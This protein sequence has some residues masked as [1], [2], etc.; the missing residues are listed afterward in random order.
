MEQIQTTADCASFF[1]QVAWT[2]WFIWKGMNEFIFNNQPIDPLSVLHR[3]RK[4]SAE[5][6]SASE[7]G[8]SL[9]P[10]VP[11]AA[12]FS[13]VHWFLPPSGQF[14]I[15]CDVAVQ[16]GSSQAVAAAILRNSTGQLIDGLIQKWC[17]S[18][19]FQGEALAKLI[20]LR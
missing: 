4:A 20:I 8:A 5:Y 10:Q 2:G 1:S 6:E 15:N 11:A 9:R 19:S 14:K 13:A 3:A 16:A 17:I 12:N 7:M 18:S